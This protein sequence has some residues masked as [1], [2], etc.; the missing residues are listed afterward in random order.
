VRSVGGAAVGTSVAEL[1][2]S[3]VLT[4]AVAE[5]HAP[6]P[7]AAQQLGVVLATCVARARS[8]RQRYRVH[9][10]GARPGCVRHTRCR[11]GRRDC[12]C[13]VGGTAVG[14][15]VALHS[16][17]ELAL[18]AAEPRVAAPTAAHQLASALAASVARGWRH[19]W[20]EGHS[21]SHSQRKIFGSLNPAQ[22][23]PASV[24]CPSSR[25][26]SS[27]SPRRLSPSTPGPSTPRSSRSSRRHA[28]A[29]RWSRRRLRPQASRC[30]PGSSP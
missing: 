1:F 9:G 26:T 2:S 14:A 22:P 5:P 12:T 25:S 7:T 24:N 15:G 23:R 28:V 27:S 21:R 29:P 30:I 8:W 19:C 10:G 16:G 20:S 3:N 17:D 13:S 4:L 6:A 18:A 11:L